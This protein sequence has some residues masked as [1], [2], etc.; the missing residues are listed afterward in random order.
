MTK[1]YLIGDE[2]T[3]TGFGLAG[4]KAYAATPQTV[5][6]VLNE[7]REDA[8]IIL[9]TNSLYMHVEDRINRV[10]ASGKIV[11]KIPD[12]TGGG[13]DVISKLIKDTIGFDIKN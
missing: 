2:L 8:D 5:M 12:R 9:V 13:E 11:I 10:R 4:V 3:A 1:L 6:Q 7:I